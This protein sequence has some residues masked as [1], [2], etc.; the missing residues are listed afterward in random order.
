ME[1]DVENND[2]LNLVLKMCFANEYGGVDGMGA[3]HDSPW[4]A[5]TATLLTKQNPQG[6]SSPQW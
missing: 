2:L 4:A 1:V 5:A 6:V 3:C